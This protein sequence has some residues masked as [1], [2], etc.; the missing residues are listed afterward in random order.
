MRGWTIRPWAV[1]CMAFATLAAAGTAA[2][3]AQTAGEETRAMGED[4]RNP[5][6]P[7]P[8]TD[9]LGRTLPT[10]DEVGPIKPNRFV[11]IFYFLWHGYHDTSEEGPFDVAKIMAAHP[12]ALQTP[13]SPPW[14]PFGHMHYWGEP[15]YGYYRTDDPWV[16]R[17]H[18]HMLAD[19]GIDCVIFDT[20]NRVTYPEVYTALCDVYT[21]IRNEGGRTPRITFMVN[22]R[23]GETAQ[24]LYDELYKPGRYEDLWFH[25]EGKPL[26]ICDPEQASEEVRAFFTLRRAHWPFEMVNTQNAWHWEA[27]Y[28]QVYG[29]TDDPDKP[30]QVNVS[31]AQ[32]LRASDGKVTN[33]SR[34]DARGRSFHN[35]AKDP[36]PD[37]INWGPGFAEQWERALELDP[38]FVMVTGWNE[39]IAGRYGNDNEPVMFVDQFDQ[40]YSRDIEMVKG[41]HG[42]NYYYQLV[43]GIRRYKGMPELPK[44]SA[45]KTIDLAGGFDQWADVA[46]EFTDHLGETIPR[47]F[48][49]VAKLHYTND[50]GRNDLVAAKVA[51]DA[52]NVCFYVRTAAPLTPH[53]DPNWMWLLIDIDQDP[54]TGWEGYD[55]IINRTPGD[56]VTTVERSTGGWNWAPAGEAAYRV[57]GAEMHLVVP[58]AALGLDADAPVAIDLKWADNLQKPGDVMDFYLSGDV[59]PEGRF[60]YRYNG[61]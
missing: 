8:A 15:L 20:T 61:R 28:P 32:N 5:G 12:D 29:Y 52:A 22:T 36:S 37:A 11:G 59:A 6:T 40:E 49:G 43:A 21:Q 56:G 18:A 60:N 34:G 35:G 57:D 19:A 54:A 13:T 53:T 50:T 3:Q 58:R 26:L 51:R 14:G 44:A 17:R 48:P 7:W 30:E 46:P 2:A 10:P 42:D 41:L 23:A 47:D 38:P 25:W 45:P 24:E 55:F 33:M 16:Q 27:A 31:V 9:A 39:W 4:T 1:W